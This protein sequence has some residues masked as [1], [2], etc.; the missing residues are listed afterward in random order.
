[1]LIT[2]PR[3]S[4]DMALVIANGT[5]NNPNISKTAKL[6][7][8]LFFISL[9]YPKWIKKKAKLAQILA[10]FFEKYAL[11]NYKAPCR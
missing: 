2:M 11:P 8:K 9:L 4:E 10:K 1:M 6:V 3:K 7:L 5:R